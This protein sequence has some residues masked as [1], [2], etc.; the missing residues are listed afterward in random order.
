MVKLS[1]SPATSLGTSDTDASSTPVGGRCAQHRRESDGCVGMPE[2]CGRVLCPLCN[3]A[4]SPFSVDRIAHAVCKL[5]TEPQYLSLLREAIRPVVTDVRRL[6]ADDVHNDPTKGVKVEE[7]H[8]R[9]F[10]LSVEKGSPS[11]VPPSPLSPSLPPIESLSLSS[12]TSYCGLASDDAIHIVR[13]LPTKVHENIVFFVPKPKSKGPYYCI[14]RG[15]AVGIFT[16][17]YVRN[18]RVKPRD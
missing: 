11:D 10:S 7:E 3:A 15:L 9:H 2:C 1:L 5:L 13:D 14:S 4:R 12:P 17:W 6:D 18:I 16:N 8:P